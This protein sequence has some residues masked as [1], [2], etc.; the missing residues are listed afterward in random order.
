MEYLDACLYLGQTSYRSEFSLGEEKARPAHLPQP[1]GPDQIPSLLWQHKA[2]ELVRKAKSTLWSGRC[3]DHIRSWLF[4][5]GITEDTA[6]QANLGFRSLEG[7]GVR[8]EWGLPERLNENGLPTKL[9]IPSGLVIPHIQ[10]GTALKVKIR[11]FDP[12]SDQKYI[13]LEGSSNTPM[14]WGHGDA[15]VI[16]ESELDGLLLYQEAEDFISVV[17]LGSANMRPDQELTERLRKASK[18]LLALDADE[19]G[20]NA[21]WGWWMRFFPNAFR[22]PIP[23][24]CGKDPSEAHQKGLDLRMWIHTGLDFGPEEQSEGDT[25]PIEISGPREDHVDSQIPTID[26]AL[27]RDSETLSAEIEPFLKS[28]SI[29]VH[30]ETTGE[31]PFKDEVRLLTLS[32]PDHPVLVI[33]LENIGEKKLAP[34]QTLF[35]GPAERIFHNAKSTIKFLSDIGLPVKGPL[36]DTMLA[37]QV[38]AAGLDLGEHSLKNLAKWYLQQEVPSLPTGN[39][40]HGRLQERQT[41]LSAWKTST[42]A[43][44]KEHLS[45]QLQKAGLEEVARLEFDSIPATVAMELNG[46]LVDKRKAEELRQEVSHRKSIVEGKLKS[47]LGDVNLDSSD[48]VL[49][50]LRSLGIP[51]EKTKQEA[52][53]PFYTRHPITK[54]IVIYRKL[55]NYLN[56]ISSWLESIHPET[57][58][59]HPEIHQLGSATG[60]FSYSNPN[61]QGTPN[62]R[63][64]RSC[65]IAEPGHKLVKA[66]YSQIELRVTAEITQDPIMI[67]A[68]RNQADLHRLTASLLMGKAIEQVSKEDR[69]KAKAVNFGLIFGMGAQGLCDTALKDYGVEMTLEEAE[70]FRR[71]FFENY[72]GIA[73]WQE[74]ISQSLPRSTRTILGRRRVW[75]GRPKIT[76]LLN[77]PIQGTAADILK[78]ALGMLPN[79]L[80]G[81]GAKIIGCVH[82]EIILEAG[83]AGSERV[84]TILRETMETAGRFFLKTVP[85]VAEVSVGDSWAEK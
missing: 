37:S 53:I 77:T 44:I 40:L 83:E 76:E 81:T 8:K 35:N 5:R 3:T 74:G 16:V 56:N 33:D 70:E 66:D 45:L 48:Q 28:D 26:F 43:D 57:G 73:A 9:R 27:V 72:K 54:G 50:A 67:E 17:A 38:L 4:D 19:A 29:S 49:Q 30:I 46:M 10:D 23:K 42:L 79:A 1:K 78:K 65:F 69:Q 41:K 36:F 14:I 58:R 47:I 7:F 75:K 24:E 25:S 80:N 82:D 55:S 22:W 52:L 6:R 85:V 21:S 84:A 15:F 2:S 12:A 34:L 63:A 32:I 20:A 31:D 62:K 13:L 60:R 18:I 61:L 71:R 39:N 59:I 51:V 11:S 64:F 68:Y